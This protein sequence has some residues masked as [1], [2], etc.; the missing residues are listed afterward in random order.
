MLLRSF[1]REY[2]SEYADYYLMRW[3]AE[4]A[5]SRHALVR[6]RAVCVSVETSAVTAQGSA[7]SD[8]PVAG[9]DDGYRIPVV[10][11]ADGSERMGVS[12]VSRDVAIAAGLAVWNWSSA[13]PAGQLN[14]VPRRSSASRS[15]GARPQN[16]H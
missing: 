5:E 13:L 7:R 15:R 9:D 14:S 16:I 8:Y 12:D 3:P 6:G 2:V 1:V 4:E 10:G 11:H